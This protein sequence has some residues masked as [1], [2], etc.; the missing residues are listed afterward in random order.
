MQLSAQVNVAFYKDCVRLRGERPFM[1]RH[2]SSR[3]PRLRTKLVGTTLL[4]GVMLLSACASTATGQKQS[5]M[6]GSAQAEAFRAQRPAGGVLAVIRYPAVVET[7]AKDKYYDAFRA[8]PI[9]GSV[10]SNAD[11]SLQE[12]IADSVIVKSNYFA[13]SLY[14][15]LAARLPEH[16][17]LL[18]PHAV[19]LGPDGRL[20][21]EPITQAES[22]PNV[23][24]VDF[25]TY[26][27]PDP[28]KM[29]GS[30]PLTFGDLVTPLITVRTDHRAAAE[31]QG[32][33]LASE[34][35]LKT[36]AGAGRDEVTKNLTKM[37]RGQFDTTPSELDF[38]SYLRRDRGMDVATQRL[39]GDA[40]F[41]A[42]MSYPLEKIKLDKTALSQLNSA[43]SGSVDPLERVFSDAMADRVIGIINDVDVNQAVMASRAAAIAEFDPS[44][45]A[46]TFVGSSSAD[47]QARA[48][49]AERL[50]EAQRKYL[51]VQSLRIF[52]GIHNGEMGVQ[53][54]DMIL[55]E[56][57]VLD[58]RRK[59][60]KQQ[61]TATALSVL[62][63]IGAVGVMSQDK[64]SDG[65]S[66]YGEY[67]LT[68]ALIQSAFYAG[69][70]A[71]SLKQQ[72]KS[73]AGNYLSSIVPALEQQTTVT[74]DLIDSNETITAI[75]YEDLQTK[76]Q[77]LYTTRQRA[78]N[79]VATRCGFYDAGG[80]TGTWM[81][82]CNG[83]RANGNGVG[84][85]QS[86]DGRAIEYYGY[87]SGGV[88]NGPGLMIVHEPNRSFTLEGNFSSGQADGAMRVAVAGKSDQFRSYNAGRDVGAAQSAPASPF[89]SAPP[90]PVSRASAPRLVNPQ[91]APRRVA[92]RVIQSAPKA[93]PAIAPPIAPVVP[94]S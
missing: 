40:S 78:L 83:G 55:A 74:V 3:A 21:S 63:A 34:D 10:P 52:D 64:G 85:V 88:A 66:S 92:P 14:K 51:S 49:Y 17:V 22:I 16:G 44:L 86:G 79:T 7:A 18:S 73:V 4:S 41:N 70:Q 13:L 45:A 15:E 87:A 84:V 53:M 81:G 89:T 47:Y 43:T 38:V 5:A 1:T 23:V 48:R 58:K 68:N 65:R 31:T 37:Q 94:K 28:K 90:A 61:N 72:S 26:S 20:T 27:F 93:A 36:A 62:A 39:N 77:E 2:L 80:A 6:V 8:S 25:A 56:Y 54:R 50:L 32:V 24:S 46:L 67:L 76:L 91:A 69:T 33:L 35:I 29:M 59:M 82:V 75:R 57:N 9:G 42:V 19:K 30:E 60:A 11:Q 71:Y 12:G